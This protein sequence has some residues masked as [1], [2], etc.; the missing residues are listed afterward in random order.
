MLA[1]AIHDW[2]GRISEIAAEVSGVFDR[3]YLCVEDRHVSWRQGNVHDA[4]DTLHAAGVDV[5][6]DPWGVGGLFVGETY[7][8]TDSRA[9]ADWITFTNSTDA[10]GVLI[11][12]PR[13]VE[14]V[15]RDLPDLSKP[16]TYAIQ[17]EHLGSWDVPPSLLTVSTYHHG[18]NDWAA[19][20]SRLTDWQHT[21][22]KGAGVWVQTWNI[23]EGQEH[24]PAEMIRYWRACG[25][26]INVWSYGGTATTS[27]IRSVN[28]AD[29]WRHVLDAIR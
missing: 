4:I 22:P 28:H 23:P 15:R 12:E 1:V 7:G 25:R 27:S 21:L 9:W 24:Q 10:D 14:L 5:W 26:D 3:A 17:P 2:D 6:L 20:A 18:P 8:R 16:L 13:S 11:D 19:N 29:V